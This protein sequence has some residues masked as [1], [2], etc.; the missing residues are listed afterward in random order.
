MKKRT[1]PRLVP[2]SPAY[3]LV[4]L[5][6]GPHHLRIPSTLAGAK[7]FG[8]MPPAVVQNFQN[9]T[10]GGFSSL[11]EMMSA[12]QRGG[13][14]MLALCGAV[15]GMS[16]FVAETD[17]ESVLKKG[18][19]PLAFGER[20]FEEMYEAGYTLDEILTLFFVVAAEWLKA[21]GRAAEVIQRADFFSRL[22]GVT[23]SSPSTSA[24][25]SSETPGDSAN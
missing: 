20:V 19:D 17:L 6:R 15:L 7:L 12:V 2:D 18:E 23:R 25:T 4:E 1:E 14:Q 9:I 24:S 22:R 16:W 11:E 13:P 21:S 3:V 8:D 5:T 10:A